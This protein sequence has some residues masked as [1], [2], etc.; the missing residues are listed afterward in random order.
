MT[1][2]GNARCTVDNFCDVW[3]KLAKEF[4]DYKNI[5]GYDIMNEPTKCWQSTPWVNIAQACINAIAL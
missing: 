4:K 1:I 5:W 2:I 3:K